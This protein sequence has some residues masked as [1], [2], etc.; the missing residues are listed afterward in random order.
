MNVPSIDPLGQAIHDYF[1]LKIDH[2]I[3]IHSEDFD[4]DT[5]KPSY[6]F[7]NYKN[8]PPLEKKALNLCR[9]KVLDVGA[10]AGSHA[11][12]LQENGF[13]VTA[14]EW[15]EKCCATMQQRGIKKVM[16]RDIFEYNHDTFDTILLLMNG[17]GIAGTLVRLFDL[18]VHL[19]KLLRP[20]GQILIDSSDLIY[21]YEDDEGTASLNINAEKY[22]GELHYQFEYKGMKGQPFRWLY[23]D[24]ES[25]QQIV[26]DSQ[27]EVRQ[28]IKGSHYDYLLQIE[29]QNE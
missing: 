4:D 17:T 2:P 20:G 7:R 19:K 18:F 22:Y 5:M 27:L 29:K 1:T 6:F 3:I 26:S 28:L 24:T 9:G 14:L 10:C 25:M 12:W 15:S 23:V 13:D 8:M 16:H 21:L 11:L